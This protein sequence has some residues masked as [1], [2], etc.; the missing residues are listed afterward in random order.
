MPHLERIA[1]QPVSPPSKDDNGLET[2]SQ[3]WCLSQRARSRTSGKAQTSR[4]KR[5][6]FSILSCK[7]PQKQELFK[8]RYGLMLTPRTRSRAAQA[9]AKRE[10][11]SAKPYAMRAA[12]RVVST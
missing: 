1:P 4:A 9:R 7:T 6:R 2:L 3:S 12:S 5:Q 8:S 11:D 10:R